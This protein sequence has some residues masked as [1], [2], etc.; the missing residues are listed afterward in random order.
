VNGHSSG[1]K[2]IPLMRP[3]LLLVGLLVLLCGWLTHYG[4]AQDAPLDRGSWQTA[5]ASSFEDAAP[6]HEGWVPYS[7][8]NWRQADSKASAYWLRLPLPASDSREPRLWMFGTA[9]VRVYDD[10]GDLLYAYDPEDRGDRLNPFTHWSVAKLPVPIPSRVDILLADRGFYQPEPTIRL[11]DEG[12]R[13]RYIFRKDSYAFLLASLHLFC[14]AIA[15]GLFFSRRDKLYLYFF[16]LALTGSYASLVRNYMLQLFWDQPWLS[17]L[18]NA[19]FPLGVFAF[20]STLYELF[21]PLHRTVLNALRWS[22][23]GFS[24]LSAAAALLDPAVYDWLLRV[25]LPPLYL[26]AATLLFRT[27]WIA[28]RSRRDLESVWMLAGSFVLSAVATVHVVRYFIPSL[29]ERMASGNSFLTDMPSNLLA[30]GLLL[31]LISLIRVTS[32]RFA[33]MN[34]ELSRFNRSLEQ[35]VYRRTA[36]LIERNAQLQEASSRLEASLRET[37]EVMAEAMVLEERHRIAGAIHD[38]VAH[39]LS[40]TI[41]Q[42]EAAKPLMLE[43]PSKSEEMV[44]AAQQLVRKGLEDIRLSV[45]ML[46][47]DANHYDLPAALGALIRDTEESAGIVIDSH[48]GPLPAVLSTVQKRVFFQALQEGL[49]GG[50]RHGEGK[51]FSLALTAA[52]QDVLFELRSDG[53]AFGP[54]DFAVGLNALNDSVS[55][56][57]GTMVVSNGDNGCL[58]KVVVPLVPAASPTL[59]RTLPENAWEGMEG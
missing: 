50:I 10:N 59:E 19:V 38:T 51:R 30:I 39:V 26:I 57:H 16:L 35:S 29:Y 27:L 53:N 2:P 55:R 7:S 20:I 54:A 47:G 41:V 45:R 37:T 43:D 25:P 21:R 58:L 6:P 34:R 22:M 31:F 9:A 44:A 36:E 28:Y 11:I 23:L 8:D 49:A 1:R 4:R 24:V 46:K 33:E 56:L 14:S 13:V 42:L 32:F 17:Y 15:L 3:L 12:D 52:G 40:A 48:I 18:E 5:P